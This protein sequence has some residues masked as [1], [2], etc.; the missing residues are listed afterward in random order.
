MIPAITQGCLYDL[1]LGYPAMTLGNGWVSGFLYHFSNTRVLQSLDELE[2]Y[3]AGRP[4]A[5]NEY[6]RQEL[7]IFNPNRQPLGL[8]WAYLM[9]PSL[10]HRL[11]GTLL[12][13]GHWSGKQA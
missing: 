3:Q 10:V 11:K 12:P 5:E 9:E 4:T 7:L 2:G 13:E 1:P 6:Q 8:A